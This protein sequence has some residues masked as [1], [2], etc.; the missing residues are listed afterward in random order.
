MERSVARI[1]VLG[2]PVDILPQEHIDETVKNLL[3]DKD[4]HQ[5]VLITLKDL[6]KARRNN[7]Y[8]KTILNASLVIPISR[9]ILQGARFLKHPEPVRYMPFDFVIKLLGA[10]DKQSKS[11]YLLGSKPEALQRITGNLRT[12]F[13]GLNIVGRHGGFFKKQS[14]H[15]IILA[16]RKAAPSLL[17][18]AKGLP[19]KD[20]WMQQHQDDFS[21]GISLYCGNVFDIFSGKKQRPSRTQWERGF[22]WVPIF[23]SHPWRIFRLFSYLWYILLLVV[24][25]IGGL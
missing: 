19:G 14:E 13:P 16:I 10:L 21:L 7:N 25:R 22:D 1:S 11:L 15:N 23:F 18:A 2:I 5:I 9:G 24:Y 17:L 6:M 8:R 20:L 3:E 4:R 12:S